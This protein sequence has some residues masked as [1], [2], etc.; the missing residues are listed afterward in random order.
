MVGVVWEESTARIVVGCLGLVAARSQL[1][2]GYDRVLLVG[3]FWAESEIL[4]L[5]RSRGWSH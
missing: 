4:R 5:L 1:V 3:A 2:A